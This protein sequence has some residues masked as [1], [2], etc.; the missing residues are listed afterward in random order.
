L[1]GPL[2]LIAAFGAAPAP[3]PAAEPKDNPYASL[4]GK[5]APEIA[6]DFGLNG[7]AVKLSDLKGKVVL[8]DFWA[9]WCGPCIAT[10]P[11]LREWNREYKDR[12]LA[13]LGVTSYYQKFGFDKDTGKLTRPKEGLTKGQE[14]SML[15][16]FLT[17][18][19]LEN[20][21]I[22]LDE[23]QKKKVNGDY[24]VRGIP[25]LVLIDRMGNVCL[26]KVGSSK[27]NA[28]ATEAMIKRLLAEK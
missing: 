20:R 22:T 17:H 12:G 28:E 9:I 1:P 19:K 5:P 6:G 24:K 13:I 3:V 11:H 8:V 18:H 23:D 7:K 16:D 2:I 14:Q 21:V 10:F 4:I 26:V 15:K 27:A 25:M